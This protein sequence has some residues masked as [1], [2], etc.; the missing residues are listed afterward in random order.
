VGGAALDLL[1]SMVQRG[2]RG[3]PAHRLN[4]HVEGLWNEGA[5]VR[6]KLV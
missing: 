1:V 6:P 5:S 4:I 2:E 3:I